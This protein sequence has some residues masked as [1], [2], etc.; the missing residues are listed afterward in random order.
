[1]TPSFCELSASGELLLKLYTRAL[2]LHDSASGDP[3]LRIATWSKEG[4]VTR[5]RKVRFTLRSL[6]IAV[7]IVAMVLAVE[8][9]L[10]HYAVE[11]V[12]S[13]DDYLWNEA[14]T[15]WVILNI[16]L[17]LPIVWSAAIARAVMRDHAESQKRIG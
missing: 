2:A 14:V 4:R 5:L 16:A 1:M 13:H 12:K 7:G 10:F 6:M 3:E 8:P 15:V 11:L 9:F 17:L